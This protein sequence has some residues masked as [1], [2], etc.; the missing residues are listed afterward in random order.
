MTEVV[1][2][3]RLNIRVAVSARDVDRP[4]EVPACSRYVAAVHR[5]TPEAALEQGVFDAF[6]LP[7]Q[8]SHRT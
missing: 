5:G 2:G 4:L 7:F 8:I 1:D 3:E 6:G